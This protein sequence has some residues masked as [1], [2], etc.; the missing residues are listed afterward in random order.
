MRIPNLTSR[1]PVSFLSGKVLVLFLLLS[2]RF[3][4]QGLVRDVHAYTKGKEGG[5]I[6]PL[7]AEER[8]LSQPQ[9]PLSKNFKVTDGLISNETH[10]ILTD[11]RGFIWIAADGGIC[12]YDGAKFVNFSL[13]EGLPERMITK[14]YEDSKGR[15]WFITISSYVG[16]IENDK[17]T[18]LKHKFNAGPG[19][20]AVEDFAHSLYVDEHDT[21]WV[22]TIISGL[23]YKCAYPY[24][25]KPVRKEMK[26]DFVL[27]FNKKGDYIYGTYGIF[28]DSNYL[29]DCSIDVRLRYEQKWKNKVTNFRDLH[30]FSVSYLGMK[31]VK[32]NESEFY[33]ADKRKLMLFK[34]GKLST[35]INVNI[36]NFYID[37]SD[38]LW[39]FTTNNGMYHFPDRKN[40]ATY[41]YY[42][43]DQ[44]FTA[45]AFDMDGGIWITSLYNGVKYIP[46]FDFLTL[47]RGSKEMEHLVEYKGHILLNQKLGDLFIYDKDLVARRLK[48][49]I[50]YYSP[51]IENNQVYCYVLGKYGLCSVPFDLRVKQK[52]LQKSY[53]GTMH[54]KKIKIYKDYEYLLG[55]TRVRRYHRKKGIMEPILVASSRI[56]SFVIVNDTMWLATNKGL[57]SFDLRAHRW[58]SNDFVNKNLGFRIDDIVETK[59]GL[60]LCTFG[61]GLMFYDKKKKLLLYYK[62]NGLSTNYVRNLY[63]GSYGSLWVGTNDGLSRVL[64]RRQNK[65]INYTYLEGYG[66]GQINSILRKE[67]DL[68]LATTN[69]FYK[70]P[71]S[72]LDKQNKISPVY[73]TE[74]NSRYV[75]KLQNNAELEYG[76]DKL[77]ISFLALNYT[78]ARNTKYYYLIKGFDDVWH[79]TN[80]L[81][82]SLN[83][84]PPGEYQFIVKTNSNSHDSFYFSIKYPFWQKWWFIGLLGFILVTSVYLLI[85]HRTKVIK[86]E[87]QEKNYIQVQIA[88]LQA[89]VIRAQMNP[90]FMFN[91]LNSIQGFILANENK[92]ANFYLGKFSSLMRKVIQVSRH[93]FVTVKEELRLLQDYIE[94]ERMRC[95]YSFQYTINISNKECLGVSIPAMIIQPFIENAINHGLSPLEGREGRLE[96]SFDMHEKNIICTISDNGIGRDR[97]NEIKLKKIRYHQSA[98]IKLTENRIDLYNKL[99][100]AESKISIVDLFDENKEPAGTQVELIIPI[101][102]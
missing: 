80:N 69:G 41:K 55:M 5:G 15:I 34:N 95:A 70:L 44:Y 10:H 78:N 38:G 14:L 18:V 76:D 1:I 8:Q 83:K 4:S 39:V 82:V 31:I 6:I 25:A 84:M 77:K 97:A 73:I 51:Y 43:R 85:N 36:V 94:I 19:V 29:K 28:C 27:E 91:A 30:G 68:Y 72:D 90:H 9:D 33:L 81:T 92:Q 102:R 50:F 46:D 48:M 24:K 61:K 87:E 98:S 65:I 32:V 53:E 37:K 59:D 52:G 3:L 11:K 62:E 96:I 88:G 57:L 99:Y 42:F 56:N 71:V 100:K 7:N 40:P 2:A 16:Y 79:K 66:I 60:W 58:I 86:A 20:M 45:M 23:L 63:M 67:G 22:S 47:F 13:A 74:V 26:S 54:V 64:L 17:I 93:D 21:L 75:K 101:I 49:S 12:R 89:N 35:E